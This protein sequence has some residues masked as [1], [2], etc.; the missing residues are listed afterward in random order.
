METL[1]KLVEAARGALRLR[2]PVELDL[3]RTFGLAEALAEGGL[4]GYAAAIIDV[5]RRRE[6]KGSETF[7]RLSQR[8]A[9]YT[10]KDTTLAVWER[11]GTGL[12]ILEEA[13]LEGTTDQE[14]LGLAAAIYKRRWEHSGNRGDLER[15]LE[16]LLRGF[17][18]GIAGD[19]GYTAINAAFALDL[20]AREMNGEAMSGEVREMRRRAWTI[21]GEVATA[22]AEK[23]A[24]G[25]WWVAAT[26]I[27]AHLGRGE[28]EEAGKWLGVAKTI[29]APGW[30]RE[31]TLR[32]LGRLIDVC[33]VEGGQELLA[34]Y[35]PAECESIAH[36]PAG[37]LGLAL[38]GGGF[39]ASLFHLGVLAR[40]AEAD[41]LRFVEVLSCVSGGSITGSYYYLALRDLLQSR[42]DEEIT[43]EDYERI[44]REMIE[45][46]LRGTQVNV[47]MLSLA[48]FKANFRVVFD[49]GY[50]RSDR[51]AELYEEHF[52][53]HAPGYA[54]GERTML[55]DVGIT[56]RDFEG[57]TFVAS[58]ENWRRR[59]RVPAL[60]LNAT[61]LNTGHSWQ[62]TPLAMGENAS[63]GGRI[64]ASYQLRKMHFEQA[65]EE[66]RQ[67]P[68]SRA[69]AASSCVPAL[70]PPVRLLSVYPGKLVALVDGAIHDN[71]G[72]GGLLSEDCRVLLVSDAAGHMRAMDRPPLGYVGVMARSIGILQTRLREA[73][74][75]ELAAMQRAGVIELMFLHLKQGTVGKTIDWKGCDTRP[76]GYMAP[77]AQGEGGGWSEV[78]ELLASMRTDLDAFSE[79]EAY[80]LMY[81]GY[82]MAGESVAG[83]A[84]AKKEKSPARWK[85]MAVEK[86]MT[87]EDA[88]GRERLIRHLRA[89]SRRAGKWLALSKYGRWVGRGLVLALAILIGGIVWEEERFGME[90]GIGVLICGFLVA[91]VGGAFGLQYWRRYRIAP[92]NRPALTQIIF[93]L[94]VL[95]VGW[96][97]AKIDLAIVRP[98]YL[99]LGRVKFEEREKSV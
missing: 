56:P 97:P 54:A 37:K 17:K 72:A 89:G 4:F 33:G 44:V 67:L 10:Y 83:L 30:E 36:G 55:P 9:L 86:M 99:R 18:Q 6:E 71:Q 70:F 20:L 65:P 63:A 13:G 21:R 81:A 75:R 39:R 1:S 77:A 62:F 24:G 12:A 60:L 59:N 88:A 26:L 82:R 76:I 3:E 52:I 23:G 57:D 50:A 84:W 7:R 27:E 25:T 49:A 92:E 94:L 58:R 43:R 73:Q 34:R 15:C 93:D 51:I 66:L 35:F 5:A 96:I 32:Q 45:V 90:R 8:L 48:S 91:L 87:G 68:L 79:L 40:L 19:G 31:S 38:S 78:Q 28:I 85:F 98:A 80:A 22:L 16:Y 42:R 64:E 29:E 41:V 74:H 95:M 46:F 61:S 11:L 47:R 69:V 2:N 53:S 14:T